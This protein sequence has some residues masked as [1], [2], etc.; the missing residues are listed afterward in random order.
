MKW[1]DIVLHAYPVCNLTQ[2]QNFSSAKVIKKS[3][4]PEIQVT[5][6]MPKQCNVSFVQK[7]IFTITWLVDLYSYPFNKGIH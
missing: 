1:P 4:Q 3:S 5:L 7:E 2:T 6:F